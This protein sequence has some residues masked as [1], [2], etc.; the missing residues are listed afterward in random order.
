M[1]F[2]FMRRI[3]ASGFRAAVLPQRS[4]GSRQN[5]TLPKREVVA[6]TVILSRTNLFFVFLHSAEHDLHGHGQ[7]TQIVLL[8]H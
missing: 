8:P 2:S 3:F 7:A 1:V 5:R 6:V 4:D